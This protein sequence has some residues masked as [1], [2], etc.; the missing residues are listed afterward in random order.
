MSYYNEGSQHQLMKVLG[1]VGASS[2]E[3][4]RLQAKTAAMAAQKPW[5]GVAFGAQGQEMMA[6]DTETA[7]MDW[8]GVIVDRKDV[9]YAVIWHNKQLQ[10]EYLGEI[11]VM[12]QK[13]SHL[14]AWVAGGVVGIVGL[15]VLAKG[16]RRSV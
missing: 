5:I 15:A 3:A 10:E 16:K 9:Y 2:L 6:A 11:P 4:L 13:P 1:S 8:Y 7:A 14:L 12:T